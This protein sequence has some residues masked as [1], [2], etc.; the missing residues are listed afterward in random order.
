MHHR[1]RSAKKQ[2]SHPPV[3]EFGHF[4]YTVFDEVILRDELVFDE[5]ILRDEQV[6]DEVILREELLH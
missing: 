6:F 5:V 3:R 4:R 2:P 1:N